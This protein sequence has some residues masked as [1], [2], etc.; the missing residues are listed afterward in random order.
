MAGIMHSSL[1]TF[2]FT[3]FGILMAVGLT[4]PAWAD[5]D[6]LPDEGRE[7]FSSSSLVS[8]TL[9]PGLDRSIRFGVIGDFG[10]SGAALAGISGMMRGWNPAFIISTGD[11][12]YGLLDSNEDNDPGFPGIQ[13]AWEFNV[14][15]YF[16]P[17]LQ[18]RADEKFP[19]QT[20]STQRFFP[21]VGNHDSA[22]DPAN[23]G[24][25]HDYLDYFHS[26]PGS[27]PRLPT[28]RE[29]VHNPEVSYY[30]VRQGPV[31]IFV[32]DA[33]VP[34]RPDLIAAQKS[35]LTAQATAST[36]R[37]KLAVFHQPPLTSGFRAAASWMT[38]DELK[39][40][41]AILCGHDHFYERL[42]YFGTPLFITGAGGQGLYSFRSPPDAHSLTRY[43]TNHSAML[44]TAD[45]YSMRLESRALELP[46]QQETLVEALTLG[47]PAPIDNEDVYTFFAEAGETIELRTTTPPPLSQPA[48]SPVLE[49]FTP[50][51]QPVIPDSITSPDGR[52]VTLTQTSPQ[53]GHWQVKVSAPVPGHG[54]YT[55]RLSLRSPLMDYPAWGARLPAGQRGPTDD[56]DQ[57]GW[58][59]LLEYALQSSGTQP[60]PQ[61]GEAWQGMS[62]DYDAAKNSVTVTFDLPSPL[63]PGVSYQLE[64]ARNPGGPWQAVAWRTTASDWQGAAAVTVLTGG[65]QPDARRTAVTLAADQRRVFF[66]L[67][68]T[69]NS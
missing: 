66:R 17:F 33:D 34:N 19:L 12:T 5:P 37:W 42:D 53:T 58:K 13:N 63:P 68:V 27:I 31:D 4:G 47:T 28:D 1:A 54:P 55:L 11:N 59:N 36:A 64:S 15:A 61:P 24:T 9:L 32:L 69:T 20:S 35:W 8:G 21:T 25:I 44:I 60:G 39:L 56:P 22:P 7:P 46:A 43:N 6:D 16:G 67:N 52:N 40:V 57:D 18:R 23:G 41:D 62:L 48:L 3:G 10:V 51:G 14:G 38:W 45:D 29:A 50:S 30:A 65:P 26:N 2:R 49:L